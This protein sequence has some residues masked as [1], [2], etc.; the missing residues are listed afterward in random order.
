MWEQKLLIELIGFIKLGDT[1][2][3]SA[4][5]CIMESWEAKKWWNKVQLRKSHM[6]QVFWKVYFKV[7]SIP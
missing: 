7:K 5:D 3:T 2:N 6:G 4:D 1:M